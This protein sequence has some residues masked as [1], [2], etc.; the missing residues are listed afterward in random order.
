M[1][2]GGVLVGVAILVAGMMAAGISTTS[3]IVG[4]VWLIASMAGGIRL[5]AH[6]IRQ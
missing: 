1:A 6:A 5:L 2:A 4:A 3:W